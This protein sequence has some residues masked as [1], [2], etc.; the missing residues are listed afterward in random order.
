[1]KRVSK[2]V[3]SSTSHKNSILTTQQVVQITPIPS[4][5][6]ST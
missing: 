2:K 4:L 1:L 5:I 6:D 3:V